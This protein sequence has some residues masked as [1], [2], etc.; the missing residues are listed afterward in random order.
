MIAFMPS[1]HV[2]N[3]FLEDTCVLATVAYLLSRGRL[4]PKLFGATLGRRDQITLALAFGLV[5]GS[6]FFFPGER[7][8]Y[9][10][11]TLA[12]AFAGYAGGAALGLLSFAFMLALAV[13]AMLTGDRHFLPV[14]SYFAII[15]S[16]LIGAAV[17][18]LRQRSLRAGGSAIQFVGS[19]LGYAF[20][21]GAA[22]EAAHV[23]FLVSSQGTGWNASVSHAG[24]QLQPPINMI[25][26][27]YSVASNGFGC[28]LL[29]LILG[30]AQQRLAAGQRHIQAEKELT[31]LRLSQLEELQA[32]L[33]PH[34]LFNALA[35]IAGLCVSHPL[36]AEQGVT[37]L[38]HLLRQ[39]LRTPAEVFIPLRE[40]LTLIRSYLAIEQL[41][42]GDRLKVE[43]DLPSELLSLLVP[44]FSLQVPVENAVQ[45]GIAPLLRPGHVSVIARRRPT[46]LVLA[47]SD[48]GAGVTQASASRPQEDNTRPHGLILLKARLKLAYGANARLRLFSM[49]GSGTLYVLKL[50]LRGE[51]SVE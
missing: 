22:A 17:A 37:D 5:G 14:I 51:L 24:R 48:N 39:F 27:F 30:D 15:T 6:E 44:R 12:A 32:R 20:V 2:I 42:L 19:H 36:A 43:E 21:A 7:Y 38:A 41:R 3:R 29:T 4:L 45:H 28:L 1:Y 34:F 8:P 35:G 46:H 40:E 33:H 25:T 23:L 31:T 13:L 26:A 18:W 9:V 47:V 49:P 10:I 16:A 50:P 11:F